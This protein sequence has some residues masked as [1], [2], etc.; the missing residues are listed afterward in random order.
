M[1]DSEVA[2]VLPQFGSPLE[3]CS[4]PAALE[5]PRWS[6]RNLLHGKTLVIS[7]FLDHGILWLANDGA[8]RSLSLS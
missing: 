3:H 7:F 1:P 5:L 8:F 4:C 2:K 6:L